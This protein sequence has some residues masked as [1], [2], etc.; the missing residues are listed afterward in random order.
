MW[1]A[2]VETALPC[3]TAERRR[4]RTG[5]Q[6]GGKPYR[7][8]H[9]KPTASALRRSDGDGAERHGLMCTD[10]GAYWRDRKV[11]GQLGLEPRT[12]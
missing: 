8:Q 1:T 9:P 6:K 11:A 4:V 12:C 10:A 7:P 2:L 3:V 5:F